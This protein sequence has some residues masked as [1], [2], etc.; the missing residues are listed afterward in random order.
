MKALSKQQQIDKTNEAISELVVD[1]VELKKAYN[2]YAGLRDPEQ[3]R[4]LEEN[5]GIGNP[6][7]VEFTPLIKKHVDALIGEY[8]GFP[9]I[10][11]ISCKDE[12]TISNIF[13]DKQ[14][15][16][17]EGIRNYLNS[18]LNNSISKIINGKDAIDSSIKE[19]LDKLVRDLD[20]SFVSEYEVAAQ[21]VVQY[22]LQSRQT[23][24][25]T[26][27]R[28]LL[29]DLLI[30]G[31]TYYKTGETTSKTNVQ[32]EVLDPLNTF[33]DFNP[34]SIYVKDS[35]R[36]VVRRWLTRSQILNKYGRD[37][38]REEIQTLKDNWKDHGEIRHAGITIQNELPVVDS[39]QMMNQTAPGYPVDNGYTNRLIPVY[40][41]E[42]IEVD[43]DFVM[44]RYQSIRI[45]ENIYITK[46]IDENVIRSQ[47]NPSYCGLSVNGVIFLNRT[48]QPYSLVLACA[49]MQD[50]YDLLIYYR[51]NLIATSGTKGQIVDISMIPTFLGVNYPERVQKALAYRKGG[52]ILI[53]SSQEGRNDNGNAPNQIY[54]GF[55]DT[56]PAQ[57]IQAIQMAIDS[58]EATVSSITGVFRERLNGIEQRDAV[59]NIKQGVANSFI[60]TKSIYQHMDLITC[61][62]L[63]DGLNQAKKTWKN[64]L[65]GTLILGEQQQKIFTALPQHFTIT[66]FDIHV[67]SST[68]VAEDMQ[69]LQAL[70]PEFIKGNAVTPDVIFEILT[71]KSLTEMKFKVKK[72]LQLQKEENNQLMQ[73][74]QK[75]DETTKQLEQAS[76]ELQK[77]QQEIQQLNQAKIQ[78]EQHK[79]QLE[80]QVDTYKAQTERKYR[81]DWAVIE[82]KKVE[83]ELAQLHDGNP[84]NDKVNYGV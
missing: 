15:K 10:P 28:Q 84:Y 52:T 24:F 48:T 66:D 81:E 45:G 39:R 26:K 41:V 79:I 18:H 59:S 75:L 70:V 65:T 21:N 20:Q 47:D 72:A 19:Q 60:I 61:E 82:N 12:S 17:K 13:R 76:Q 77:A 69:K 23:D 43:D 58:V 80:Y 32:Y 73:L 44:Q 40:E 57:A 42:W 22:M 49:S 35:Y 36:V 33:V 8:L 7:S 37:L 5:F 38:T 74:Q 31:T 14:L 4:Y 51:D 64:G 62:M 11:K 16:I 83:I 71:S 56:I 9:T 67:I 50:K 55:D 27:K 6:T 54:N 3:F 1:K 2:Y 53:D 30:T 78:L 63:T 46:G 25:I 29:Q 34:E 68:E